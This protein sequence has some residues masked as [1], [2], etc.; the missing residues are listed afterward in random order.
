M[1]NKLKKEGKR[2]EQTN[3]EDNFCRN[4]NS[5]RTMEKT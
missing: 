5:S 2:D 3:K 4:G 1:E